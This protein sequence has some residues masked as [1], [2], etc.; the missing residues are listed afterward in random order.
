MSDVPVEMDAL[1]DM[2]GEEELHA[3]L[4]PYVRDGATGR[5]LH[6]PLVI[7]PFFSPH[8]HRLANRQYA[9][10]VEALD[11]AVAAKDWHLVVFLH[12]RPYRLDAFAE[13]AEAMSDREYWQLLSAI[14][15]DTESLSSDQSEWWELLMADRPGR[16]EWFMD[17]AD[18]AVLCGL[19][20]VVTV[21]RGV[22]ED[23]GNESG[24]SWTLDREQ[25]VWFATRF[26]RRGVLLEVTLERS[27]II[28]CVA[29]RGEQ[30]VILDPEFR[31]V[32]REVVEPG[33]RDM[34]G[35][36]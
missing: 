33:D 18:R 29:G 4:I 23:G 25:A 20:D 15:V 3:D 24:L 30:E 32:K 2:F 5:M 13:Y 14:W 27:E 22:N 19:P 28:A 26:G 6:H 1:V 35:G 12:E 36:A 9:A 10:K 16:D 11:R 8:M 21:W 31:I 34:R 17:D 7:D